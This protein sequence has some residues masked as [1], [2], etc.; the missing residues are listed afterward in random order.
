MIEHFDTPLGRWDEAAIRYLPRGE[1]RWTDVKRR[2]STY[3]IGNKLRGVVR[4]AGRPVHWVGHV[5]GF[6][7]LITPDM[8]IARFQEIPSSSPLTHTRP[9]LFPGLAAA[10]EE[11]QSVVQSMPTIEEFKRARDG[12]TI[13]PPPTSHEE[14][15]AS[16]AR[17]A[18]HRDIQTVLAGHP[19]GT[20]LPAMAD[21]FAA[22][23][24]FAADNRPAAE[25]MVDDFVGD[26][27]RTI[28]ENWEYIRSL[29]ARASAGGSRA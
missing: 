12:L 21:S 10:K 8:S 7:W 29:R 2:G 28:A 25:K 26:L 22:V 3:F 19:V 16:Q 9:K 14:L 1:G 13:T 11:I 23:I 6:E 5:E 20:V 4:T 18:L 17:E 27:K 24:A 15:I